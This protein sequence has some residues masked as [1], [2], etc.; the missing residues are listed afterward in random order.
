M[1]GKCSNCGEA[2]YLPGDV[3]GNGTVTAADARLALRAS[4]SL[5]VLDEKQLLSAD[6]DGIAGVTAADARLILRASVGL[7]T[8]S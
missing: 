6:V 3:D 7:E 5:E 8:L 1:D 2:E 4:V